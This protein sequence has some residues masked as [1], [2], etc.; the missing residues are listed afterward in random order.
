VGETFEI[1]ASSPL[2]SFLDSRAYLKR[3]EIVLNALVFFAMAPHCTLVEGD[4]TDPGSFLEN[5]R[6]TLD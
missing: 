2:V 4:E 1:F 3:A 6:I 5:P